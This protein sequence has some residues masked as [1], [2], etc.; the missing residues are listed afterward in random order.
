M[1][2]HIGI[3]TYHASYNYGAFLQ[4]YSL[5]SFIEK[6]TNSEVDIINYNSLKAKDYYRPKLTEFFRDPFGFFYHSRKINV[7]DRALRENRFITKVCLNSDD[8][9]EYS[10]YI[11]SFGYDA[12]IVGSD[13]IWKVDGL[14]GFPNAYWLPDITNTRKLSYA[15]SSRNNVEK[16]DQNIVDAIRSY[17]KDFEYIGVR[18]RK[19][20]ELI[21]QIIDD[22]TKCHLN[23]DPTF[24]WDFQ[25]NKSE[26]KRKIERLYHLD[27]KKKTICL[28]IEKK[29]VQDCLPKNIFE[30]FNCISVFKHL[31]HTKG[32][33]PPDP[34]EWMELVAGC[35][36][37]I[38]TFFHG[39]VFSIKNKTPFL[40][41]EPRKIVEL[42]DSKSFDLLERNNCESYFSS[43]ALMGSGVI[44]EKI[45]SFLDDINSNHFEFDYDS[46]V[47]NEKKLVYSFVGEIKSLI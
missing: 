15:A 30:Q 8:Q 7:F 26:A 22:P 43:Y 37:I 14:R 28:M 31:P 34:F 4:A 44:K 19:T 47:S 36:A 40:I 10:D 5:A 35:D 11:S 46:F 32:I 13:E 18:D 9:K 45:K 27:P 16:L 29:E 12:I 23:C 33:V 17:L 3:L 41:V 6:M 1:K 25:I 38:T 24:L 2:K 42:Y 21:E 39:M 20:K